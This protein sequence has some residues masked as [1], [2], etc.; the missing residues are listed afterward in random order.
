MAKAGPRSI[1]ACTAQ[2]YGRHKSNDHDGVIHGRNR[3]NDRCERPWPA[4]F[5]S[6]NQSIFCPRPLQRAGRRRAGHRFR[7]G[8]PKLW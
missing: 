5:A 1:T 4:R 8:F 2:Y 6:G 3:L 7:S